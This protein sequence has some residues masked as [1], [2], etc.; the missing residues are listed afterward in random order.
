MGGVLLCMSTDVH[1]TT[2]H[3]FVIYLWILLTSVFKFVAWTCNRRYMNFEILGLF[4]SIKTAQIHIRSATI[5]KSFRVILAG[6][7]TV[8]FTITLKNF[9]YLFI[10]TRKH[11]FP[12]FDSKSRKYKCTQKWK[13]R[14]QYSNS[15]P[16]NIF[17]FTFEGLE[18]GGNQYEFLF[19]IPYFRFWITFSPSSAL[20]AVSY[21]IVVVRIF[22]F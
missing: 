21:P 2:R 8:T 7:C 19:K 5:G 22:Y 15:N 6:N 14:I 13:K 3:C 9:L 16:R 1:P 4:C 10:R 12:D 17:I 20:S 11:I 18:V